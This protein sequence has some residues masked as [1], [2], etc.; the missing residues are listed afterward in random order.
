MSL[1]NKDRQEKQNDETKEEVKKEEVH[2][3]DDTA[4]VHVDSDEKKDS[5]QEEEIDWKKKAEEYHGKYLKAL[6]DL[7]NYRRRTRR[8]R[9]ELI[10]YAAGPLLEKLLPVGDNLERALSASKESGQE[11]A[12]HQ[13]VDI[14]YRQF[15]QV[16][17]E[18][19]LT[20]I[21]SVGQPFDP[22]VHNAVAQVES[23]KYESGIVVEE[24]QKGYRFKD[25]VLRPAMVQVSI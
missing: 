10:K 1:D 12:L 8:E 24:L 4:E 5:P 6:A 9:E 7:E 19:G 15:M 17:K 22:H 20:P 25:R 23:D 11:E 21:E 3:S 16:L 13:G 14:I 2:M 18:S